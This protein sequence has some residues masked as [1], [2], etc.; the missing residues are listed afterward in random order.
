MLFSGPGETDELQNL[1]EVANRPAKLMKVRT[2]L[3]LFLRPY[4]RDLKSLRGGTSSSSVCI[5]KMTSPQEVPM[6]TLGHPSTDV[7][8]VFRDRRFIDA[9]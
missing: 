2:I 3:S 4:L 8:G 5:V 6:K 7:Q 9:T 1:V